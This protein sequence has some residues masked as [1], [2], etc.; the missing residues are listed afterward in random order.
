MSKTII[1]SNRLPVRIETEEEELT[2]KPSEGGLATGLGSIFKSGENI[3]IGWPGMA[4][5]S[6]EE[7]AEV[8]HNLKKQNMAPVF[9]TEDEVNDYYL[10]FSN[11]TLWPAYHYFV[12]NIIYDEKQWEAY[13]SANQK[14]AD[15]VVQYLDP[16]D[17]VWIHDYQLLLLPELLREQFPDLTIG[18]FQHIPFPSYEVFRMIPWR[19]ELLRG[20]LGADYIAFH[21][22]DDMRHFLSSVHRVVGLAYDRN[23]IILN[24][25]I[26]VADSLPMGIDYDKYAQS[27]ASEDAIEREERYRE[28]L[29]GRLILSM[30]RLDY[31]KGI[32]VRLKA[33]ERFLEENEEYIGEVSLLL[34]VV[35]SRDKV[36]SYQNLKEEIDE[37]VGKINGKFGRVNWRPI[38]Y[39]YRS[40]PLGALS[41]FYRMCE[42]AMITPLRDG[43]NL[44]C[45]EFIASKLDQKGVLILSEMAGSSKELSDSILVNPNDQKQLVQALKCGLEMPEEEQKKRNALMQQ[46]LQKYNIF[47]WVDLFVSNLEKVKALQ[48]D[49]ATHNFDKNASTLLLEQYNTSV[50]RLILLDYDGTLVSF[51]DDPESC[52]PGDELLQTLE[53]LNADEKNIVVVISGRKADHLENWLGHLDIH[54][55]AEHGARYKTPNNDWENN[56]E[57][58]DDQWKVQAKEIINFYVDRTP[59]SFLEEKANALVWHYRKVEKGLGAL[60]SSE[61]YSHLR[62]MKRNGIDVME[63]NHIVEVKPLAINKGKIA[64]RF[65]TQLHP[66]FIMALGDDRTDEYT[67]EALPDTA[68]TIKVGPG[69]SYAR[70][71]IKDYKAVRNLLKK[72]ANS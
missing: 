62:Y 45:K 36:P 42:I 3:W 54:L 67:F 12:Q 51:H 69:N 35:P 14:F 66:D 16:G 10:G 39:F 4:F 33:Y 64:K 38:H 57:L 60:R 48:D 5:D 8:T 40:F 27:A 56:P 53:T 9:L 44:V 31:S 37:L 29:E 30:D 21:T 61:L 13:K 46:S 22:Y 15:T 72:L 7:K 25:R 2:Y 19:N 23:E 68:F 49:L 32:S 11:Q 65:T 1:I 52:A 6:E 47:K 70:Y 58:P 20:M 59:G 43:M 55:V 18:F 50:N 17:I 41:A 34:I 63:G 24:D 28:N 71:S 26:V